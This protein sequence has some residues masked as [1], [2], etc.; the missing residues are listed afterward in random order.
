MYVVYSYAAYYFATTEKEKLI[1]S[2]FSIIKALFSLQK[3]GIESL[4]Q[5]KRRRF[6]ING[7][8]TLLVSFCMRVFVS[9]NK[10]IFKYIFSPF[11][12]FPFFSFR[13]LKRNRISNIATGSIG[14]LTKLKVL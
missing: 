2:G 3:L 11:I 1:E 10:K 9:L 12:Y 8:F 13:L 14:N 4:I 5:Y 7:K 6:S